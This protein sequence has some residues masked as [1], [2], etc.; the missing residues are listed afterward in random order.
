M[1]IYIYIYIYIYTQFNP[2]IREL[3]GPRE[4]LIPGFLLYQCLFYF[5]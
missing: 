3:S 1:Y 4:S 2:D 5:V